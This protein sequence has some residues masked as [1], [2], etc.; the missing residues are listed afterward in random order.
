MS[1]TF[2]TAVMD[3]AKRL[4]NEAYDEDANI[5][6][7]GNVPDYGAYR[8]KVGRLYAYRRVIELFDEAQSN[9]EKR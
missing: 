5:V 3:E 8:E 7:L 2:S 6:A 4:I 1:Q 9:L